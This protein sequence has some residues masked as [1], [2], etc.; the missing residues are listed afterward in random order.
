M[1][2]CS[3]TSSYVF[4]TRMNLAKS[5][6]ISSWNRDSSCR[7]GRAWGREFGSQGCGSGSGWG[8]GGRWVWRAAHRLAGG[9]Q[10]LEQE[11]DGDLQQRLPEEALPHSAAVV[12]VF[13]PG[14]RGR[15]VG[16]SGS[17]GSIST[18]V[19]PR[20]LSPSRSRG[21]GPG[22]AAHLQH[23]LQDA[24]D[25]LAQL[26]LGGP[27]P[28]LLVQEGLEGVPGIV[29]LLEVEHTTGHVKVCPPGEEG[30]PPWEEGMSRHSDTPSLAH[31]YAERLEC[32]LTARHQHQPSL[33]QG[34]RGSG[35]CGKEFRELGG[36]PGGRGL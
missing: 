25:G 36:L 24:L 22:R 14:K 26:L 23:P 29:H 11:W 10:L 21:T 20:P 5:S 4:S 13:L 2:V 18:P 6:K 19:S 32:W 15:G 12:V 33:P 27:L 9:R 17:G 3:T 8:A 31:S 1:T 34:N 28:Q 7:P 35:P 16:S 30:C